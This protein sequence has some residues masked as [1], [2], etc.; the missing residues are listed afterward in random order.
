M[1][2]RPTQLVDIPALKLVL[3]DTE[4]FPSDMLPDM[5]GGFLSGEDSHDLWLTCEMDGTAIGFCYAVPEEL[6]E[7][8]WNMRAIAVS[9][10]KQGSGAGAA[11]VQELESD[12]R[13]RGYR[14]L[15]ADT[16]GT[17]EFSAT[18]QFYHKNGYAEE[19]RIRDFWAAGDDK[20]IFRKAL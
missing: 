11:L 1:K 13:K 14:I 12:L 16:S 3:D 4:L 7:G 5:A 10:S 15:I 19:A 20:I 8:T 9:P 6:T 17:D 18:R 2:V